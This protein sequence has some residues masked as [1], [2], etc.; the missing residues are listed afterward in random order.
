MQARLKKSSRYGTA[1]FFSGREFVKF[2]WRPIPPGFED[3]ARKNDL[4]ELREGAAERE[5][6]KRKAEDAAPEPVM[7]ARLI[8]QY[9]DQSLRTLS[10]REY[11]KT[12]WRPVPDG[13]D[14]P[15]RRHE[16]LE[17]WEAG[18]AEPG[19]GGRKKDKSR[20]DRK[21]VV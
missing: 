19:K 9:K 21:S 13:Y 8:Q 15:A 1:S 14:E 7:Q 2:E 11:V 5:V 4:L 6:V 18:E 16:L 10:G 17:I 3:Q 12:E 20:G